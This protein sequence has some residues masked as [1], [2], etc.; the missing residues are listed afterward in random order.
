MNRSLIIWGAGGHAKV[1]LDIARCAG[2]FQRLAIIDDDPAKAG[3][4]FCGCPILGGAAALQ[5]LAGEA[6][7]VAV[8]D[9]RARAQCFERALAAGL[10]PAV[11]VHP[12]A[13]LAASATIG[14]GT[15][16]M[17]GAI[18][19]A[20][21]CIAENCIINSGAIV[22]HD[23]EI[24]GHVHISPRAVLGGG[25]VVEPYA[26]VGIGAV[27]LPCGRVGE[28]SLVGAGAVVLHDVQAHRTVAGVPARNLPHSKHRI[29]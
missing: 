22:E 15:V 16:V 26:Q 7:T 8:G 29:Q 25:V 9:N 27:V 20:G 23:C 13:V 12:S 4:S 6:F 2:Q 24:G 14:A 10:V 3:M 1:V 11:L 19:N 17:P 21:A 5:D 18:V 28:G